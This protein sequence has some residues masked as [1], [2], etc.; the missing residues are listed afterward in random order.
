VRPRI[1]LPDLAFG[2]FLVALGAATLATTADLT[3]GRASDMGPGY[4]PRGLAILVLTFGA[5]LAVRALL[6]HRQPFPAVELR[7]LLLISAALALFA[8]LLPVAGLAIAAFAT[9]VC[10]GIAAT[11]TRLV[12]IVLFA[13]TLTAFAVVLFVIALGMPV[14]IWPR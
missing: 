5:G 11:D 4:V 12:E 7:P 6:A 14:A 10:A 9:I 3:V 8:L 13:V 1:D 2:L